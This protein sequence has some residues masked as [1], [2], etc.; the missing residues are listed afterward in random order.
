MAIR[1]LTFFDKKGNN[2]NPKYDKFFE[3][4]LFLDKVSTGL[5]ETEHLFIFEEVLREI[6]DVNWRKDT[7]RL[8]NFAPLQIRILKYIQEYLIPVPKKSLEQFFDVLR[9]D[10]DPVGDWISKNSHLLQKINVSKAGVKPFDVVVLEILE[11]GPLSIEYLE[12]LLLEKNYTLRTFLDWYDYSN[13][14]DYINY[15]SSFRKYSVSSYGQDVLANYRRVVDQLISAGSSDLEEFYVLSVQGEKVVYDWN[16]HQANLLNSQLHRTVEYVRPRSNLSPEGEAF[17]FFNWEQ[18][19]DDKFFI[20]FVDGSGETF[21]QSTP[22]LSTD[23]SFPLLVRTTN[24]DFN[25]TVNSNWRVF[26]EPY[27]FD[28]G[29]ND[30]FEQNTA[31]LRR[32]LTSVEDLNQR[33]LQINIGVQSSTEGAFRRTLNIWM[34]RTVQ[35]IHP[36]TKEFTDEFYTESFIVARVNVY[37]EFV[38]EEERFRAL[39]E[40]FGRRV[41]EDYLKVFR[42]TDVDEESPDYIKL[43][44]KRKELLIS[45]DEIYPYLGSYKCFVNALKFFGFSDLRLKEYFINV[46]LL[47]YNQNLPIRLLY[48]AVD[49]PLDLDFSNQ[50]SRTPY[51][52]LVYGKML[53]SNF[54]KKTSRFGLFYDLNRL[55]GRYDAHGLP[56]TEPADQF[57]NDEV[58][59]KL[60]G[61]KTL[62]QRDFLPHHTRIIDI[63]GEGVYYQRVQ[64][65]VWNTKHQE[66]RLDLKDSVDFVGRP[67]TGKIK[68]LKGLLEVFSPDTKI[69]TSLATAWRDLDDFSKTQTTPLFD[70]LRHSQGFTFDKELPL[71]EFKSYFSTKDDL[72]AAIVET[73]PD[74]KG[75]PVVLEISPRKIKIK[76]MHFKLS[77]TEIRNW[78]NLGVDER[79]RLT[80]DNKGKREFV[81]LPGVS[82]IFTVNNLVFRHAA[83][84]TWRIEHVASDFF[85]EKTGKG[86]DLR[87]I[88]AFLPLTG[89]YSVTL[90]VKGFDNFPIYRRRKSYFKVSADQPD[91]I[92]FGRNRIPL[93]NLHTKVKNIKGSLGSPNLGSGVKTTAGELSLPVHRLRYA[94]YLHQNFVDDFPVSTSE[95]KEIT[96][97]SI[98][99][100]GVDFLLDLKYL[101]QRRQNTILLKSERGR[102]IKQAG[103]LE[104]TSSSIKIKG[105]HKLKPSSQFYVYQYEIIKPFQ[106]NDV[107][108]FPTTHLEVLQKNSDRKSVV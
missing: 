18:E 36:V 1:H 75:H 91:I 43:N 14:K 59:I 7:S 45:G 79:S 107:L 97:T 24:Q 105:E 21:Q 60:Y 37:A 56:E 27:L 84:I 44:E 35:K 19:D 9:I 5:F 94:N 102:Q 64:T 47:N 17:L 30:K 53:D 58:L 15:D 40:N 86:K 22:C 50:E 42:D 32:V 100:K 54:Y 83:E 69:V 57:T 38:A 72:R 55:T 65:Q 12:L 23:T 88:I 10:T 101:S 99:I 51:N 34:A 104:I 70:Y 106:R 87:K 103:V 26:S 13:R 11:A 25:P 33:P 82:K 31:S 108:I 3:F 28:D 20:F 68:D 8:D 81:D 74:F 77:A 71:E 63:S 96:S 4:D 95:V 92:A 80:S 61:L 78:R 48:Q 16:L 85:W 90:T 66:F 93:K 76:D 39:L 49:I 89:E 98:L 6:E 73:A 62:L 67:R 46:N 52:N 29:R 41:N 2:L